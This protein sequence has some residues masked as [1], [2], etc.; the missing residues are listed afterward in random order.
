MKISYIKFKGDNRS[1][2]LA[3]GIGMDVFEIEEPEQIDEELKI[4]KN[5]N[6]DTI[7][8]TN[9]LA[10]FSSDLINKYENDNKIKII[11]AP[12]KRIKD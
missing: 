7:V 3:K 6:Y 11:I 4:L 5:Q 10:S 1:F 2:K 8:I 9:E 12:N